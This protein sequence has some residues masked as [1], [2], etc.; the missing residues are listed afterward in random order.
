[1]LPSDTDPIRNVSVPI[2]R[3]RAE[4]LASDADEP[5]PSAV[6]RAADVVRREIAAVPRPTVAAMLSSTVTTRTSDSG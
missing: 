3:V 1:M 2:R 4:S 6:R 5:I